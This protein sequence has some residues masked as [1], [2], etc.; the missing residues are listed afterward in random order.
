MAPKLSNRKKTATVEAADNVQ[1]SSASSATSV[2]VDAA[3]DASRI[4]TEVTNGNLVEREMIQ[5]PD[6]FRCPIT[7]DVMQHPVVAAD[8]HSYEKSALKKH[9]EIHH[10]TMRRN[11]EVYGQEAWTG[12]ARSPMT[13]LELNDYYTISN[14][15]LKSAIADWRHRFQA[16]KA[17]NPDLEEV[18]DS[19]DDSAAPVQASPE[20][21]P[22]PHEARFFTED[23]QNAQPQPRPLPFHVGP[24]V[25]DHHGSL[26][27][28]VSRVRQN[29]HTQPRPRPRTS[30]HSERGAPSRPINVGVEWPRARVRLD[31]IAAFPPLGGG[32]AATSRPRR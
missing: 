8:G 27:E 22:T 10:A 2:S 7:K 23:G 6:C 31:S 20:A 17:E 9:I 11:M 21:I 18:T 29:A 26:N 15:S 24:Q 5:T 32:P 19:S 4:V 16:F 25:Q 13:N 12:W 3:P 28:L 14:W 1:G 30:G